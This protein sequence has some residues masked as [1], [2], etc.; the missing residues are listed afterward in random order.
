MYPL[1]HEQAQRGTH[2]H[3]HLCGWM[4][5]MDFFIR[6]LCKIENKYKYYIELYFIYTYTHFLNA[7][8]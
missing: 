7:E 8:F 3:F 4:N 5:V 2:T 6:S 1:V